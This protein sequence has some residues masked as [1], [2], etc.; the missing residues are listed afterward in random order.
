MRLEQLLSGRGE[1]LDPS[2]H[3]VELIQ[4]RLQVNT[5]RILDRE[6]LAQF[7]AAQI[8]LEPPRLSVD[9][10]RSAGSTQQRLQTCH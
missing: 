2:T 6:R 5:H 3:R 9:T 1:Q 8:A 10:A 7:S 4:Q